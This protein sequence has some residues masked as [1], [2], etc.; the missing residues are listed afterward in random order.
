VNWQ[1]ITLAISLQMSITER[2][3]Y[4]MPAQQTRSA[5]I[6]T[7][8][9]VKKGLYPVKKLRLTIGE[10]TVNAKQAIIP[11]GSDGNPRSWVCPTCKLPKA[12]RKALCDVV[13]YGFEW[14]RI[15]TVFTC[16]CGQQF[17][18]SYLNWHLD[19]KEA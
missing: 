11:P 2:T 9:Y 8:Q 6:V 17:Y 15:V 13:Q 7:S 14:D 1:N 5:A 16:K 4:F 19:T 18:S 10:V 3:F 12:K